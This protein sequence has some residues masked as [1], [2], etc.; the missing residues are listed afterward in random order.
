MRS[1]G[2]QAPRQSTG[3]SLLEVIVA[4]AVLG[5]GVVALMQLYSGSLRSIK[6]AEDHTRLL[7]YARSM[8]DEAMAK[9]NPEGIAGIYTLDEDVR[10]ERTIKAV[11]STETTTEYEIGVSV[12]LP[13]GETVTLSALRTFYEEEAGE[14]DKQ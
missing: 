2:L 8:M 6:K 9:A 3:F 11:Y 1:I 5:V 10:A 13:R 4:L 7:I 14:G 12:S